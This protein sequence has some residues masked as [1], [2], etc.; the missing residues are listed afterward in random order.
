M[1]ARGTVDRPFAHGTAKQDSM[2]TELLDTHAD[3]RSEMTGHSQNRTHQMQLLPET[4]SRT[5]MRDLAFEADSQRQGQR[6]V[7]ARRMQKK[8]ERASRRA[9]RALAAAVM[10]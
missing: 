10:Q 8:A 4:L 2:T 5:R 7:N 1:S 9:R 6:L 3:D